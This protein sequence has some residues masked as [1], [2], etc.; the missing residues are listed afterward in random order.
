M[1]L[2][3]SHTSYLKAVVTTIENFLEF[4]I[5]FIQ[6]AKLS[7]SAVVVV[8][9][10]LHVCNYTVNRNERIMYRSSHNPLHPSSGD[11][12]IHVY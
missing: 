4:S 8:L 11:F 1:W 3:N 6:W 9:C 12:F 5:S 2:F 7:W 10:C